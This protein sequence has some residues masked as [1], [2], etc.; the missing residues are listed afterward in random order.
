MIARFIKIAPNSP[1]KNGQTVDKP[2]SIAVGG[3]SAFGFRVDRTRQRQANFRWR[4]IRMERSD[5]KGPADFVEKA[6]PQLLQLS[7]DG[8]IKTRRRKESER[9]DN[10]VGAPENRIGCLKA[11]S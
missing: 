7:E 11:K 1:W 5:L 2:A 6:C 4:L 3:L 10:E 8:H 9:F